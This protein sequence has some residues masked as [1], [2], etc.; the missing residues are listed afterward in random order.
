LGLIEAHRQAVQAEYDALTVVMR[1]E[2][3]IPH[4]RR[5]WHLRFGTDDEEPPENC[6]DDPTWVEALVTNVDA[7]YERTDLLLELL[8]TAPTTIAGVAALLAH[9]AEPDMPDKDDDSHLIYAGDCWR[10]DLN[11]AAMAFLPMTGNTLRKLL[12]A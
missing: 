1:L 6:S 2:D 5:R 3:V 11:G 7:T 12:P 8:T 10:E 4:E 9:L